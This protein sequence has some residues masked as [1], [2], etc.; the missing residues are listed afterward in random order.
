M[1]YSKAIFLINNNAR[2]VLATYEDDPKADK[3]LFKTLDQTIAEDDY[4]IVE[5]GTRHGMTVVKIVETDI[6]VDFDSSEQ[7]KWVIGKI[8]NA[9]HEQLLQ[10]E[11]SAIATIKSAELRKKREDLRAA[12]FADHVETI[13]ALPIASI[14]GKTQANTPASATDEETK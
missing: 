1:N 5:T 11:K 4:V 12:M 14:N 7:I 6:D 2:A 10:Q 9:A 13:K 8:D 3:S